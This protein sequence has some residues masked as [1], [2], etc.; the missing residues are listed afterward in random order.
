[1]RCESKRS[2]PLV[3]VFYF[4]VDKKFERLVV[5]HIIAREYVRRCSDLRIVRI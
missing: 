1:M 2:N 5:R 4:G 3:N